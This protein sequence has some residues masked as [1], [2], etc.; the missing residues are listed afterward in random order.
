[1]SDSNSKRLLNDSKQHEE[2]IAQALGGRRQPGSGNKLGRQGDVDHPDLYVEA[3]S[4]TKESLRLRAEWL[5]TAAGRAFM[6]RK[7][8]VVALSFEALPESR[9]DWVVIP[10]SHFIELLERREPRP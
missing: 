6:H 3:K 7:K 9:R 10:L 8:P 4:T 5:V 1:M 2:R